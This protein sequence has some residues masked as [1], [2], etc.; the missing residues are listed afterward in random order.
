MAV[1]SSAAQSIGSA[2]WS[3]SSF[4]I[5]GIVGIVSMALFAAYAWWLEEERDDAI[6]AAR[7]VAEVRRRREIMNGVDSDTRDG[8]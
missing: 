7:Q 5:G 8:S 2:G 3:T 6:S 1:V 4:L